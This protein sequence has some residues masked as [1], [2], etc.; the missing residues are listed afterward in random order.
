MYVPLYVIAMIVGA[1]N[2]KFLAP[3]LIFAVAIGEVSNDGQAFV[4]SLVYLASLLIGG[5]RD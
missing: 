1:M 4:L 2:S 3:S 5:F